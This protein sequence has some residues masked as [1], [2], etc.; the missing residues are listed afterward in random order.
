MPDAVPQKRTGFGPHFLPGLGPESSVLEAAAEC[1]E[2]NSSKVPTAVSLLPAQKSGQ[3]LVRTLCQ[4]WDRNLLSLRPRLNAWKPTAARF[5]PQSAFFPLKKADRFRSAGLGLES[6]VLDA[7]AKCIET[8]SSKVPTA[9][10]LLPAQK[11]GQV[12]VRTYVLK[13]AEFAKDLGGMS[14]VLTLPCRFSPRIFR[15]SD[16]RLSVQLLYHL[17]RLGD[18]LL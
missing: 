1:M 14:G 15:G 10:S 4:G 11:S 12:L 16:F 2:A 17:P 3:V 5:R 8:N 7:A 9:V 6:S 18:L 13:Y